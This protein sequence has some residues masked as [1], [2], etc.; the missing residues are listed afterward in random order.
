M[1][2]QHTDVGTCQPKSRMTPDG[3]AVL[4]LARSVETRLSGSENGFLVLGQALEKIVC[5]SN[6]LH[7]GMAQQSSSLRSGQGADLI[8]RLE[9]ASIIPL[10]EHD[11]IR[12]ILVAD[13]ELIERI[14]A[15]IADLPKAALLLGALVK[16]LHII[17][18]NSL[19]TATRAGS[20]GQRISQFAGDVRMLGKR[21]A[22]LSAEFSLSAE[23][24]ARQQDIR[25]DALHARIREEDRIA[26]AEQA[27]AHRT[28]EA[29]RSLGLNVQTTLDQ[30]VGYAATL[31]AQSMDI[32][33]HLQ[34]H[35]IVRQRLE[36][37]VEALR[38]APSDPAVLG[39]QHAQMR[40]TIRQLNA[41]IPGITR[42]F[43][44][45]GQALDDLRARLAAEQ[46]QEMLHALDMM[47]ES[48]T[49]LEGLAN[50]QHTIVGEMTAMR[51]DLSAIGE[52]IAD[53]SNRIRLA[54]DDLRLKAFNA[55]IMTT[56]LGEH[57]RGFGV[58]ARE[59]QTISGDTKAFVEN[60]TTTIEHIIR[61]STSAGS[62]GLAMAEPPQCEQ[63]DRIL[64]RL[65][66]MVSGGV[67]DF[68]EGTA[69]L[70]LAI[71]TAISGSSVL[72]SLAHDLESDCR[73]LSELLPDAPLVETH[74]LE[75]DIYTMDSE[76]AIH[77][78]YFGETGPPSGASDGSVELF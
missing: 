27:A 45:I 21:L 65:R 8:N 1:G 22:D 11:R 23:T 57:G 18:L 67:N 60:V 47:G 6:A 74:S 28:M 76:R 78:D 72:E 69:A 61:D 15:E 25:R 38:N 51:R 77:R 34:I 53:F 66:E 36:H 70:S 54:N 50:H 64:T 19:I 16:R 68:L 49:G 2:E 14:S 43:S 52:T 40:D 30:V 13:L 37:I 42:A 10:D 41:A 44:T 31:T 59:V 24:G 17:A 35:D 12:K 56:H 63:P 39:L 46:M 55:L 48:I 5:T 26:E 71:S 75:E 62:S 9:S 58:L 7:D 20:A 4:A 73:S 3:E 33:T 32:I 29:V